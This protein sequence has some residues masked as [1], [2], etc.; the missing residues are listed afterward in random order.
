MNSEKLNI[1]NNLKEVLDELE[2]TTKIQEIMLVTPAHGGEDGKNDRDFP[3]F[4]A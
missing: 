4:N 3:A 2:R 1:S